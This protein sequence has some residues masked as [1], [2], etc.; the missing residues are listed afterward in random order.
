MR[1]GFE[2]L[3]E[4]E[5]R[6]R[7]FWKHVTDQILRETIDIR[8]GLEELRE[9]EKQVRNSWKNVIDQIL[10]ETHPKNPPTFTQKQVHMSEAQEDEEDEFLKDLVKGAFQ[11]LPPEET[12][13]IRQ[14]FYAQIGGKYA[15][16]SITNAEFKKK[17]E[18]FWQYT[19]PM[20]KGSS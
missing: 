19:G 11:E 17:K 14:D 15:I 6:L 8:V 5:K 12:R 16:G 3:H 18:E 20:K 4:K 7:N 2:E 10:G 9:K 13:E 1:V